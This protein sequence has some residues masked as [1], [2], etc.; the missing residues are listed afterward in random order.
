MIIETIIETWDPKNPTNPR[1][2]INR[3]VVRG[4][5]LHWEHDVTGKMQQ[6]VMAYLERK[7]TP[8]S[9]ALVIAYIQHHI[10]APCWLESSPYGQVDEEMATAIRALRERSLMLTTAAE[11][12]QYIHAALEIG[13]DPL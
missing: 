3:G 9:L 1:S 12:S 8:Q 4:T 13:L 11:V 10:H 6:A 2:Y 5:P 7:A